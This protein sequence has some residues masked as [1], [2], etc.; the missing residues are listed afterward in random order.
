MQ[1]STVARPS[2][3]AKPSK[4]IKTDDMALVIRKV[5]HKEHQGP[6]EHISRNAPKMTSKLELQFESGD[7][8]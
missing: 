7:D 3:S 6:E 4:V 2:G 8:S 5:T 1:S